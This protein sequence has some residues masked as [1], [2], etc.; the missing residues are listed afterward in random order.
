MDSLNNDVNLNED[1]PGS[2]VQC[3]LS[4]NSFKLPQ[5]EEKGVFNISIFV[6]QVYSKCW[7]R[8]PNSSGAPK[9]DVELVKD[10]LKHRNV[11]EGGANAAL[12]KFLGH[13]WYLNELMVPLSLFDSTIPPAEKQKFIKNMRNNK[14]FHSPISRPKLSAEEC[15]ELEL[16]N[17]FT[18]N[19]FQF[20]HILDIPHNFLD[21]DPS[22]WD[23]CE[24]YQTALRVVNAL[25]VTNDVA[26][27]AIYITKL[28]SKKNELLVEFE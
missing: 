18:S 6:V 15:G 19:S 12:Y 3:G 7:F 22:V 9:N 28:C 11:D 17:L 13:L 26:E 2:D 8:A 16:A 10:L 14:V 23:N 5:K 21:T 20:F 25:E 4:G 1:I 24:E 27:R